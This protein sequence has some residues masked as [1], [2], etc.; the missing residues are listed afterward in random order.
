MLRQRL[1]CPRRRD[2]GLGHV[3]ACGLKGLSTPV[4]PRSGVCPPIPGTLLD[5]L[6]QLVASA[7]QMVETVSREMI[8]PASEGLP[9]LPLH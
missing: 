6:Y 5:D 1:A 4:D 9:D 2:Q 7:R 8:A 3:S